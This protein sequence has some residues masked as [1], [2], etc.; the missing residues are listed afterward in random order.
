MIAH[1]EAALGP[2]SGKGSVTFLGTE[3]IDVLRFGPAPDGLIRYATVGMS[4]HP[5][6]SAGAGTVDPAGPRAELLLSLRA[7]PGSRPS[8][9]AALAGDPGERAGGRGCRDRRR[10][11]A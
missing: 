10:A 5:M 7:R 8:G 6:S 1:L 4:T 9:G 3:P 11:P 2:H